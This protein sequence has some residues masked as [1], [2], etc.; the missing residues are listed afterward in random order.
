MLLINYDVKRDILRFDEVPANSVF[1]FRDNLYTKVNDSEIKIEADVPFLLAFDFNFNRYAVNLKNGS[2]LN[3]I[4]DCS[5]VW[6]PTRA[7]LN[8][9]E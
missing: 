5:A 8:I 7:V 9:E 1:F 2:L 4:D 6:L 3:N